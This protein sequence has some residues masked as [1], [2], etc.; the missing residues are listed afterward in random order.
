LQL[1]PVSLEIMWNRLLHIAEECWITIWRTAFSTII[2]DAQDFGCELLDPA[3]NSLAH[4]ARSMPVFNLSLPLAVRALLRR[5]PAD[6]L[7]PGDVLV[8]NDPWICAGHLFDVATVTPVF[9][10]G[11]LVALVGSIGHCSDIGGT[12]DSLR[13]REVYE[14]G[15]QIPPGKLYR[16]GA[17]NQDLLD[18]IA[19]NV[20]RPEMVLGDIHAQVSAN[21][22][23]AERLAAFMDEYGLEDLTRL[24]VAIQDRAE[25]AM[26]QAIARI[27]DGVF[28]HEVWSDGLGERPLRLPVRVTVAGSEI[29]VD[30][31]GAP[32][33]VERGGIN[34]TFNYTASHSVYAL[35]CVLTPEIPSNAGCYRP[36]R[37]RAPEGSIL[38][39]RYPA[40]VNLRTKTGWYLASAIF[41]ALAPALPDRVKAHTAQPLGVGAYGYDGRGRLFNDHLLQG[42]GAGAWL[43]HD[44]QSALLFPTSAANVSVEMFESRTPAVVANKELIPDSGGPGRWRGGLGQ[45]LVIRKLHDDGQALLLGVQPEGVTVATPGLA[46]GKPGAPAGV[47]VQGGE[48]QPDSGT[49]IL[50]RPDESVTIELGGGSGYGDPLERDPAAVAADVRL[51]LVTPEGANRDYGVAVRP[52]G[53]VD[54]V[55]TASL[56]RA[57]RDTG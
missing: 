17:P 31:A 24:A 16:A 49:V 5:F 1:D 26:R 46:G 52:D 28:T 39:C 6:T 22:V 19:A 36:I 8:T 57:R 25:Q 2:G 15:L 35:K 43:G 48:A 9:R 27:P 51:G 42:G 11:R 55:V 21:A 14:E 4:S 56:R 40:S 18:L 32:P 20:R 7:Q 37:V 44:G 38:N 10:G 30:Y 3:G 50:R 47:R 41:G 13:A 12:K 29:A 34:C 33:Q 23:G 54:E 45:R 53:T